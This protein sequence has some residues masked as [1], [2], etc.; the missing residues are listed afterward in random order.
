[1]PTTAPD[2]VITP[3]G[4]A[5]TFAVLA[6]D[7]GPGLAIDGYTLPA[8]GTLVLDPD[9]SFTYTP[10]PGF[11]G[12]DGFTYTVRDADGATAVGQVT[13]TVLAPNDPPL[14]ADDEA[15][16]SAAAV[17]I[18]VLANDSDPD[19]DPVELVAVGTPAYGSVTVNPDRSLTYWPQ[20][21]FQGTDRFSYTVSD[22]RGASAAATVTVRVER[23]NAPPVGGT[24]SLVTAV[25]T[26][27]VFDPRSATEDPDGDSLALE[28]MG[29]PAAGRL[30]VNGDGTLTYLPDAGFV[31]EDGFTCTLGDGRGGTA[32]VMVT[33]R[34]ERPNSAPAAG[35]DVVTT[36]FETPVTLDPLA[37]DGDPD[38][39][40]LA[41]ESLGF[42]AHGRLAINGDGTLTYTPD[43]GF[44]GEDAFTYTVTDGRGERASAEVRITVAPPPPQTYANGY[45][46]RRRLLVPAQGSGETVTGFV[47]L[48]DQQGDWLRSV[49]NGGLVESGQGFDLRFE[50]EDGTKL[51]HEIDAYDPVAGRLLAWVRIPSWDQTRPLHLFLY[52]GRTGLTAT[53]ADPTAVWQDYLA[54]WDTASGRDRT[55]GGRDLTLSGVTGSQLVGASGM[56]D[57]NADERLGGG[58]F[59]SGLEALYVQA[60]VQADPAILGARNARIL[61]QGDPAASAGDLGLSLFYHTSGY[62]GGAPRTVKFALG[63]S[64]GSVQI[65][66]PSWVQTSQRQVLAASWQSGAL[67]RLYVDGAEVTASW[68][69]LAGQQGAVAAGATSMVAGQPLS[70]GLGALNTAKSWIGLID[71]VRISAAV[72]PAGRLAA[73]AR[74]LLDPGAFYGIGD[75]EQFADGIES[76]VAAPLSVGT[77]PGQWVE[78][79]PLAVSYLPP[80]TTLALGQQPQNGIVS[81]VGGKIRYTPFAGFTGTDSFTYTLG[82]GSKTAEARIDVTVASESPSSDEFPAPLRTIE[83][84]T[85]TE[86]DAALAA[87]QPGDHIV[88][89][90]G[91]YS[92]DFTLS[93]NGTST[94]PIIVRAANKLAAKL[95]GAF[96][97]TGDYGIIYG[98]WFDG[99]S[100]GVTVKG[101]FDRVTRCKFSDSTRGSVILFTGPGSDGRLDHCDIT[102]RP[103]DGTEPRKTVRRAVVVDNRDDPNRRHPR[104]R[105]DRNW[106]HDFGPKPD[107]SDYWSGF[108]T[109]LAVTVSGLWANYVTD[110]IIEYNLFENLNHGSNG[111]GVATKGSGTTFRYNTFLNGDTFLEFRA[112]WGSTLEGNWFERFGGAR[113]KD[114]DHRIIG[115]KMLQSTGGRGLWL[116]AGNREPYIDD[117]QHGYVYRAFLAYNDL[118]NLVVGKTWGGLTL[119]A[120]NNVI[121]AHTGPI[122]Y[123]L[124]TG[125]IVKPT[126]SEPVVVPVR[127]TRADVGPNAP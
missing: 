23:S 119:P 56:F 38:G 15:T 80:G 29:L 125:T 10:A 60:V 61:Q 34:V 58:M 99:P 49:A 27:V 18:D 42:P 65:E 69:G 89:A 93:A 126:S 39:D 103:F 105:I 53:E 96:T 62:F 107:P 37:N 81:L 76:P 79:D 116:F 50:L 48:V 7:S 85:G 115:N 32:T 44:S 66:G 46:Y 123:G 31:G 86:L 111:A 88:L 12:I 64:E 57:G 121:E 77:T 47:L 40:P 19:G 108:N 41:L 52:Y 71:E 35:D 84:S 13:I 55:A 9:Q 51:A 73:E 94:N 114:A 122:T 17:T 120:K 70:V 98:L 91:V 83:V 102:V 1:M 78:I 113:I 124:H 54:V 101:R 26:P 87:A 63:T 112:G 92:G 3:A 11:A 14:P 95:T 75:D 90:D 68:A 4:T 24:L 5:V 127:L 109:A 74:N 118:D 16:T 20:E 45:A 106:I 100:S 30:V 104:V 36:S 2:I 110:A 8:N 72:P 21:G 59:L 33:V 28:G 67:P 82:N 25:D 6:N 43:A 117:D 97:I 22:R